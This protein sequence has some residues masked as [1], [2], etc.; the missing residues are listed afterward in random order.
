MLVA[1]FPCCC[2]KYHCIDIFEYSNDVGSLRA[3]KEFEVL[4]FVPEF[5][6]DGRSYF[7][8]PFDYDKK[9]P[10]SSSLSL[11][12]DSKSKLLG[13]G[14]DAESFPDSSSPESSLYHRIVARSFVVFSSE[15][16]L[17]CGVQQDFRFLVVVPP[18]SIIPAVFLSQFIHPG[19][20]LNTGQSTGSVTSQF[21]TFDIFVLGAISFDSDGLELRSYYE[22]ESF[23]PFARSIKSDIFKSLNDE[24]L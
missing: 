6:K 4:P 24:S 22:N 1:L 14:S 13:V 19:V 12:C 5:F 23:P 10:L 16:L 17:L 3:P 8:H 11:S 7:G 18:R 15:Y 9:L 20:N 2:S 21:S